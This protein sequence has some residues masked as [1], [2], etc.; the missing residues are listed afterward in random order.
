MA[1]HPAST[2]SDRQQ[3]MD[4]A[5]LPRADNT[6]A[7][8]VSSS[9][10]ELPPW[11]GL[12]PADWQLQHTP[13]PKRP[14]E[15]G[16]P[17][18]LTPMPITKDYQPNESEKAN[19]REERLTWLEESRQVD[20][21][22]REKDYWGEELSNWEPQKEE[23]ARKV[24]GQEG[25]QAKQ[26]KEPRN[27]KRA[28]TVQ[29][30]EQGQ[31]RGRKKAQRTATAQGNAPEPPTATPVNHQRDRSWERVADQDRCKWCAVTQQDCYRPSAKVGGS[32]CRACRKCR[33]GCSLMPE[34]FGKPIIRG[35]GKP[36]SPETP[37]SSAAE[38][39]SD[40]IT[41]AGP[42]AAVFTS[43]QQDRPSPVM[44]PGSD[45]SRPPFAA[46][47][48]ALTLGPSKV[49]TQ[50]ALPYTTT[51]TSELPKLSFHARAQSSWLKRVV[52]ARAP[53]APTGTLHPACSQCAGM[54]SFDLLFAADP[55][56]L[57][58]ELDRVLRTDSSEV[59][60]GPATSS[61]PG[62]P[63]VTSELPA[64]GLSSPTRQAYA[65]HQ[66]T[67]FPSNDAPS[68]INCDVRESRAARG[69]KGSINFLLNAGK[70]PRQATISSAP[71]SEVSGAAGGT[72]TIAAP[73]PT[74]PLQVRDILDASN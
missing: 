7:D 26:P 41:A 1:Q 40:T 68:Q 13:T 62:P 72:P 19:G 54:D 60:A 5:T 46:D 30:M 64:S 10:F 15:L 48:M 25:A 20:I 14:E 70:A 66:A 2:T 12:R 11:F 33:R 47:S 57:I 38:P 24:R 73:R 74:R 49:E 8:W 51:T 36:P 22:R 59:E 3:P 58:E 4:K 16:N 44:S 21:E 69:R 71:W 18:V 45:C 27:R 63:I 43:S 9:S 31:A 53:P 55:D 34:G 32:R 29:D 17:P 61:D 52:D 39:C 28:R 23:E 67:M 6:V 56:A 37:E 35:Q 65:A 42:R 50:P